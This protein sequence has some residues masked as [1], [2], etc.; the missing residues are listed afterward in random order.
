MTTALLIVD[1]QNDYFPGGKNPLEGSLQAAQQAQ[2]LLEYFRQASLPV[3]HIRHASIRP[4]ATFFIP[5]TIGIEIHK[6]VRPI[7]GELQYE[8]NY[9]NS[10][11][12]TALY[13]HLHQAQIERLVIC[14]MMTHMCVE[15]TARAAFDLGFECLVAQDACATKALSFGDETIPA[16]QIQLAFLAALKG[17][18]AQIMTVEE[19]IRKLSAA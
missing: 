2:R 12:D 5:G 10:F 11:R 4:G 7:S 19:I 1:I 16:H 14:G 6:S 18:Y 17:V 13:N 9:P 3:V 8:K 15:A